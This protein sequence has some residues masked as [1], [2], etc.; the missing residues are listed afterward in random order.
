MRRKVD[1]L[2]EGLELHYVRNLAEALNVAVP[3]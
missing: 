2:P 1:D 3:K